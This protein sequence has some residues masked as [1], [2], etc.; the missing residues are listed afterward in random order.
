[1]S[2]QLNFFN[3]ITLRVFHVLTFFLSSKRDN[4]HQ[5]DTP[6]LHSSPEKPEA[7]VGGTSPPIRFQDGGKHS[8]RLRPKKKLF[9]SLCQHV[10]KQKRRDTELLWMLIESLNFCGP[11][12]SISSWNPLSTPPVSIPTQGQNKDKVSSVQILEDGFSPFAL[13]H[14][15]P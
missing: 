8:T 6:D 7:G 13:L 12:I 10:N 2:T 4:L 11:L 1:M 5:H 15:V 3:H 9:L 14:S